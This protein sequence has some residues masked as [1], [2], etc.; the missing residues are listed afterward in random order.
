MITI[1]TKVFRSHTLNQSKIMV[2]EAIL[3]KARFPKK[4]WTECIFT[5]SRSRKE[6]R[7]VINVQISD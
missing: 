6:N 1:F 7:I 3:P 4:H 5:R 2:P